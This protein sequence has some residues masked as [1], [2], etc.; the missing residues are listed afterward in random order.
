MGISRREL[1]GQ[2]RGAE[3][4]EIETPK[5]SRGAG[6]RRGVPLPSRLE[7]LGERRKLPQLR[8]GR[9]PGRKQVLVHL[10]FKNPCVDKKISY[11]FNFLRSVG[12]TSDPQD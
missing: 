7:G 2:K 3:G 6:M 1:E 10:S 11:F 12:V 4:G 5:A 9:S 8:S